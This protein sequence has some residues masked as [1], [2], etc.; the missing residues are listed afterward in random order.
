[1]KTL[2]NLP[3]SDGEKLD[4]LCKKKKISRAQAIREAVGIYLALKTQ[5]STTSAFG[6]W[7]DRNLDSLEHENELRKEWD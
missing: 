1:M 7:K 2:I 4:K 6:A 5:N 3:D